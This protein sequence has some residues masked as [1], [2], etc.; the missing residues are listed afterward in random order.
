MS[1]KLNYPLLGLLVQLPL[2]GILAS[3]RV[4]GLLTWSWQAI[5]G[6]PILLAAGCVLMGF[7][8][9]VSAHKPAVERPRIKSRP[10]L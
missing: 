4:A 6:L 10:I 1:K 7:L 9:H 2:L 8:E 3:L 5:I